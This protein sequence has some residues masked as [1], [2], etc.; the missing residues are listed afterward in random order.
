[1]KNKNRNRVELY[2][3]ILLFPLIT[4]CCSP[5][6]K[7]EFTDKKP[8]ILTPEPSEAPQINGA[9]V[10]G[11]RPGNPIFFTIPATGKRPMKFSAENLPKEVEL[12]EESGRLTGVIERPDSFNIVLR[13]ENEF[14]MSER[15]FKIVVGDKLALT[16]PMGWNS[17]NG[18]GYHVTA[19]QVKA[20]AEA[21]VSTGLINHGWTYINI[22]VG[23]QGERGGK[24]NAIQPNEKFPDMKELCDHIHSLGLK[25]GIY[26][27]PWTRAY[28]GYTGGSAD[29]KNGVL[30]DIETGIEHGGGRY[31]GKYKFDK[32][33]VQQWEEWG[34]DYIKYD[35]SSAVDKE[36]NVNHAKILSEELYGCN[37]D[38]V[39][40]LCNL[41][42]IDDAHKK[43][44]HAQLWRTCNDIR[45]VWERS[46]LEKDQWAQGISNI[47]DTHREWRSFT[48][49]GNWAD[50]D[51]LAL[52]WVGFGDKELHKTRLSPDEQYT[53]VSL[54]CLFS[55][56][57][58]IGS[59]IEKLDDFTLSL[60]SNDE[61]IEVNQDP[62]GRQAYMARQDNGGEIWIKRMEDGSKVVGLFN[63]T[64]N[65]R[66]VYVNWRD[67]GVYGKQGV[68]DLW[69]Q[70]D[71]GT[72]EK[73]FN[74]K[75]P[76]H[77][78]VLVRLY[79]AE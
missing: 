45:D 37:R 30:P 3:F 46:T 42:S 12:D 40:S 23:W 75:V 25:I 20:T 43:I 59:P 26:S 57:L 15:S 27:T 79:P 55:A 7:E 13:A 31:L 61:V 73:V 21:M 29:D 72:Y 8:Y 28:W 52:G 74:A 60:L 76:P 62:L 2:T 49:P 77:G 44:P 70:K 65:E 41:M 18:W 39:F 11:V 33:D 17:W 9:K 38:I 22:D 32:N 47:W 54:W 5:A 66:T 19:D 10:F 71:L 4:M 36:E 24:Y 56:P 67:I 64:L 16:P 53:H 35:W 6:D 1:M 78:V 34:I 50:P 63:R 48:K 69:R 68:R 58:F 14:G 51:M